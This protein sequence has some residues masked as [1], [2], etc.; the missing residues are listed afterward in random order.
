[1]DGVPLVMM[2]LVWGGT[3]NSSA[4]Y[5]STAVK[6][7]AS[8]TLNLREPKA[9]GWGQVNHGSGTSSQRHADSH[10]DRSPGHQIRW[11]EGESAG[12]THTLKGSLG[13]EVRM[14]LKDTFPPAPPPAAAAA[15]GVFASDSDRGRGVGSRARCCSVSLLCGPLSSDEAL[16]AC[17]RPF[18]LHQKKVAFFSGV[19]QLTR[20]ARFSRFFPH[21]S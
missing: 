18:C 1:M 5:L 15:M 16:V 21:E 7:A 3:L 2:A 13:S 19:S 17:P 11:R 10:G 6:G 20:A 4:A 9:G 8:G 12:G 14:I